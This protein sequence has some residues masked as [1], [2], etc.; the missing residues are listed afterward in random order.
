MTEA[1]P[2]GCIN[3]VTLSTSP[4]LKLHAVRGNEPADRDRV[5]F[6]NVECHPCFGVTQTKWLDLSVLLPVETICTRSMSAIKRKINAA[7]TSRNRRSHSKNTVLWKKYCFLIRV[8]QHQTRRIASPFDTKLG[9]LTSTVLI[10]LSFK[11]ELAFAE[12]EI[13]WKIPEKCLL[14][15]WDYSICLIKIT[16]SYLGMCRGR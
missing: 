11:N 10:S 2:V 7:S 5:K 16:L 4:K 3:L 8:L 13:Q 15:L 14:I 1:I 12:G 6:W 9:Q